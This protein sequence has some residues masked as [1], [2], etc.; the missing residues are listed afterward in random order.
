M[1]REKW[2]SL[3][4]FL[5]FC[6][7]FCGLSSAATLPTVTPV[8]KYAS[9]S[10]SPAR[11]AISGDGKLYVTDPT[12]GVVE[13]F[14]NN[15]RLLYTLTPTESPLGIAVDGA[16][17]M[18]ISD[19][20]KKNVGIYRGVDDQN[21]GS[22]LFKVGTGDNEFGLPNGVAVGPSGN[23]YVTDSR[24]NIVKIFS[25]DGSSAGSFGSGVLNFPTGIFVDSSGQVYV[26]DHNNL[27]IRYYDMNGA[28]LGAINEACTG[29][30]MGVVCKNLLRPLGVTADSSHVYVADA[31]HSVI[32]VYDKDARGFLGYI[33]QYG[34]AINEY[35]TPVDL[36]MDKD[37]KLFVT[38][39]NN[40]RVEVLGIDIFSGLTI[41][42]SALNV[43]L[44]RGGKTVAADLQINAPGSPTSWTAAGASSWISFPVNSGTA[45][46]NAAAV[47]DPAG[48]SVGHY[49]STI[50]FR[51]SSG[52]ESTIP[53]ALE[54]KKPYLVTPQS[55]L[56]MIYQKGAAVLPSATIGLDSVGAVLAWNAS[57]DSAW[58]QIDRVSGVTPSSLKAVL[59]K[60]VKKL[61][62]GSYSANI[63]ITDG[64][65]D[66]SSAN[67]KVR[68]EVMVAGTVTVQTNLDNAAFSVTGPESFSG[69]GMVWTKENITPG[70]YT[71]S[72]DHISGYDRPP[73]RTFTVVSGVASSISGSYL[74][75]VRTT[76]IL[77]GSGGIDGG[78]ASI[79][80]LAGGEVVTLS[81]FATSQGVKVAAGDLNGDGIDELVVSNGINTLKIFDRNGGLIMS[82]MLGSSVTDLEIA[83]GD[84]DGDGL[85]DIVA[86]Y[87]KSNSSVVE[88]YGVIGASLK[89]KKGLVMKQAG[90]AIQTLAL[91]DV[92]GDGRKDL[93]LASSSSV[94]AYSLSPLSMIWNIALN[95]SVRPNISTGD[96]DDDGIAEI[97]LALGPDVSNGASVRFLKG[98]GSDYGL[99]INAFDGYTFGATIALGDLDGDGADDIVIGAGPAAT[100]E[101]VI[102]LFGSDGIFSGTAISA[103]SA[104]YGAN[105]GTGNF[106]SR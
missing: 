7:V 49:D 25:S 40:Q 38:N 39:S 103:F 18:V 13:I 91:G 45:P 78:M 57:S 24:D 17:R 99:E 66:G 2:Q 44:Y 62:P 9:P 87:V 105:A 63:K 3:R 29:G 35:R 70:T 32:A 41:L 26:I 75:K 73:S 85:A 58:L 64:N 92:N 10:G 69:T 56:T 59:T 19:S 11:I 46:T 34:D 74:K 67:I 14:S 27:Y 72:F 100:N 22:L 76:H 37:Q 94:R 20:A 8:D 47:F 15:G 52:V 31:Y 55:Q 95:E 102:K 23:I 80:P 61:S 36:A 5:V 86:A 4:L 50:I 12:R 97:A 33:G 84:V 104:F 65:A 42:P 90:R 1:A 77:A 60:S 106:G 88:A 6:F 28:P 101:A 54:V 43:T 53:V 48:L 21:R 68:L 51:T 81:P 89:K 93:I 71:L 98:N 79:I 82:R 16:G 30:M 83:V 96:I